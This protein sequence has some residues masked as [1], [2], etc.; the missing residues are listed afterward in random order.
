[1][2][3]L[4]RLLGTWEFVM[5]HSAMS[6]PVTGRQRY[7]RVLD[8]A[9]LLQHWTYS[10]PD[11]PDAMALLS[12]DRY[13]YFDVRGIVRVFSLQLDD[14]GW[15][16]VHLDEDFSQCHTA[17]FRGLH[18]MDSTGERSRDAG[19]TWQPDFTMTFQRVG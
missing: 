9:F 2:S 18:A 11:F 16:M 8:G 15:R 14:T 13:Y 1:M 3:T 17:R 7:E 6:E 5:H 12:V 4:D 19:A 10:H